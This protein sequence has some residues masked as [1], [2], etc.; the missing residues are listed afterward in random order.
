MGQHRKLASDRQRWVE[1][2]LSLLLSGRLR[3]SRAFSP[4][5][6]LLGKGLRSEGLTD[7]RADAACGDSTGH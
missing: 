6:A 7:L 3:S 2:L 1:G 4:F 5:M